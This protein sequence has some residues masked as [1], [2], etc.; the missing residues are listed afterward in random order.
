MILEGYLTIGDLMFY[1]RAALYEMDF[2]LVPL[3]PIISGI[4]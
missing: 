2:T 1:W 3:I 4:H